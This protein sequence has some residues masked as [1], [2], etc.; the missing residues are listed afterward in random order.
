MWELVDRMTV[1]A[2]V[3]VLPPD[4]RELAIK[5]VDIPDPGPFEVIVAQTATGVCHSQLHQINNR[6]RTQ[7]LVLGHE[8]IGTVLATGSEVRYVAP[9]DTVLVSWLPRTPGAPRRPAPS[10]VRLRSGEWAYTHNI[11][12]WATHTVVDEQFVLKAP[13]GTPHDVGAIIGC[14]VMTGA[15]AVLHTSQ[16]QPRD[17]VVIWG[18]GG[19]GLSAVAAARALGADPVVAVDLSS[20]KLDLALALGAHHVIDASNGDPVAR[21]R[22]LTKSEHGT[23]ADVALDCIGRPETVRQCMAS[24][25]AAQLGCGPGGTTVLVGAPTGPL[26]IDG[27]DLMTGEKRLVGCRGGDCLPERDYPLFV[28]WHRTG[29]LNLD[30]LVTNRYSLDEING[31]IADLE[32]GRVL[33]RAILEL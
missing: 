12:G 17:S 11:F 19:V 30:R 14:A 31:A 23:G 10:R 25:R 16:L 3:A 18:V 5:T 22:E 15:G 7:P 8:S 2:R 29:R 1:E 6:A 9:G 28:E 4:S 20:E 27:M 32:A 13:D 24:I 21:V 26:D 33:G